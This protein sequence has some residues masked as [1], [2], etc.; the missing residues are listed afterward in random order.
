MA[1][2]P[3]KLRKG[4]RLWGA[5]LWGA[6]IVSH[7]HN[8]A[9]KGNLKQPNSLNHSC[10]NRSVPRCLAR[11]IFHMPFKEIKCVCATFPRWFQTDVWL[12]NHEY[13]HVCKYNAYKH[14]QHNIYHLSDA[15]LKA[16]N[17]TRVK[18]HNHTLGYR[19][20]PY[21]NLTHE[22]TKAQRWAV[23]GSWEL[24]SQGLSLTHSS[25]S[26]STS[27]SYCGKKKT[28]NSDKIS[29]VKDLTWVQL[30]CRPN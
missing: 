24:G 9:L 2:L 25:P 15:V 7:P 26:H 12:Q 13:M 18:P 5:L 30:P 23:K 27:G 8:V 28:P 17:V 14:T 10:V 6:F 3:A 29:V 1:T 16:I 21:L 22:T 11:S 19:W 20:C 4:P